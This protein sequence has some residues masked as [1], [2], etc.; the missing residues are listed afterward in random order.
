MAAARWQT[1]DDGRTG[2]RPGGGIE[3]MR[4]APPDRLAGGMLTGNV[5]LAAAPRVAD[6]SERGEDDT[7]HGGLEPLS[8]ERLIE[9]LVDRTKVE[10]SGAVDD[11]TDRLAPGRIRNVRRGGPD[12]GALRRQPGEIRGRCARSPVQQP[13]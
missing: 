6:A 10:A 1:D 7:I 4:D 3:V 2:T 8:G 5:E 9:R 13:D 11:Q 12:R